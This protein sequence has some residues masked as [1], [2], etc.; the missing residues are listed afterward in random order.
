MTKWISQNQTLVMWFALLIIP[1][2]IAGITTMIN[3]KKK[4]FLTILLII[5]TL[6]FLYD[7]LLLGASIGVLFYGTEW[8]WLSLPIGLIPWVI[9]VSSYLLERKTV[10]TGSIASR[11]LVYNVIYF[12][13]VILVALMGLCI[14]A[15][16][17]WYLCLG[18]VPV[19]VG[20]LLYF[21]L[22]RKFL[23]FSTRQEEIILPSEHYERKEIYDMNEEF[24]V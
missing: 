24:K 20:F 1:V 14:A 21:V 6:V 19:G 5:V 11:V 10:E 3:V 17:D 18:L 13:I 23:V 9:A 16:L 12:L 2:I 22:G 15:G 8:F 7:T 4:S